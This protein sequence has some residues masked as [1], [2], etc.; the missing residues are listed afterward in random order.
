MPALRET[1]ARFGT[2]TGIVTSSRASI[3]NPS[4]RDARDARLPGRAGGPHPTSASTRRPAMARSSVDTDAGQLRIEV[5]D[6]GR[7]FETARARD[8]LR[9]GASDSRRCAS[10]SSSRAAPSSCARRRAAA[11]SSRPSC[12]WTTPARRDAGDLARHGGEGVVLGEC[13]GEG[14]SRRRGL[15]PSVRAIGC[16]RRARRRR[17]RQGRRRRGRWDRRRHGD[18]RSDRVAVEGRHREVLRRLARIAPSM[19]SCQ[20]AAGMVPP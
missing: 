17:R 15:S 1:L 12:R 10:G 3:S 18:R 9:T 14:D 16:W 13:V 8:F 11:R 19:K 7:G 5:E 4:P 6:D 20:I 2:D